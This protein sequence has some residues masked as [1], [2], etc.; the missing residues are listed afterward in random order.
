[1]AE[2]P[3]PS[4]NLTLCNRCNLCVTHCPENALEMTEQG[5][6]FSDPLRC[7]YCGECENLCP[8][9]AIRAPL[10]VSWGAKSINNPSYPSNRL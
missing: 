8:T 9:G 4:I 2:Q 7:T 10:S 1:M 3:I 6:L 5:P